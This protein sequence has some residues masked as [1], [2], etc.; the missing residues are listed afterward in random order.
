M[1][2]TVCKLFIIIVDYLWHIELKWK[3]FCYMF[4][5]SFRT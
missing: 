4:M 5:N 3:Q 2:S 1:L